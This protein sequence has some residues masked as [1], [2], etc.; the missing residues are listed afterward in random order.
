MT[1][2]VSSD[3]MPAPWRRQVSFRLPFNDPR[4]ALVDETAESPP[5]GMA[6]RFRQLAVVGL[7]VEHLYEGKYMQRSVSFSA[8]RADLGMPLMRC[9]VTLPQEL[10]QDF[11]AWSSAGKGS[12]AV[13]FLRVLEV[14]ILHLQ[15]IE[16]VLGEEGPAG[17]HDQL[18]GT[19]PAPMPETG[20]SL[21]HASEAVCENLLK[22][23]DADWG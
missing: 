3:T 19:A 6:H 14:A 5:F 12:Y 21:E 9:R 22:S 13:R 17:L 1:A 8:A 2:N 23:L 15:R 7:A 20:A 16:K 11:Q 18:R 10:R 4:L